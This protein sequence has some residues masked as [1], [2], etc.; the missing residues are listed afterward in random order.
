MAARRISGSRRRQQILDVA[1]ELFARQG[2]A[3]T[4]TRQI[5]QRAGVTEALVFRH[6]P[7]KQDLYWA[8][9]DYKCQAGSPDLRRQ[10]QQGGTERQALAGI[11]EEFFRRNFEDNTLGRLLLFSALEQHQLSH[12]F[13]RTHVAERYEI[14]ADY[15]RR[16]VREGRFRRVNPLLAA[17]CF[18]GMV[19]YHFL[20]QEL[21]GGKREQKF[22]SAEVSRVL[23]EIWH[24]GM[25]ARNG[26]RFRESNQAKR[27]SSRCRRFTGR[28]S[29]DG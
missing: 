16:G 1:T 15:I 3:G 7:R 22:D 11:A 25:R 4:T 19:I 14:L 24:D 9:I 20:I 29:T 13:F 28:H 6:F 21:F 12:R 26:R 2:F 10:L 8:V 5:A 23:A 27:R 17:R 18:F